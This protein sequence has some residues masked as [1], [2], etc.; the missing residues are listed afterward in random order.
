MMTRYPKPGQMVLDAHGEVGRCAALSERHRYVELEDGRKLAWSGFATGRYRV[1]FHQPPT[2]AGNVAEA[3]AGAM[4]RHR[5]DWDDYLPFP[6]R[7]E[8]ARARRA[9][10]WADMRAAGLSYPEIAAAFG[11]SH[12][13]VMDTLEWAGCGE[14]A[15]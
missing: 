1:D 15:R 9:R 7:N 4:H 3:R 6:P 8:S 14:A 2:V 12:S 11:V 5:S 13:T 10:V